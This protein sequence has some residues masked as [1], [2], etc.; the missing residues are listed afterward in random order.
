MKGEAS[1]LVICGVYEIIIVFHYSQAMAQKET[2]FDP[3]PNTAVTKVRPPKKRTTPSIYGNLGASHVLQ[4]CH[5]VPNSIFSF[6][7]YG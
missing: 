6:E 1:G 3:G 2:C 4:S 5:R 7:N